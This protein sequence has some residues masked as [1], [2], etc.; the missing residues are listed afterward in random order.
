[1][2]S[3]SS[4]N[5]IY[6]VS[7]SVNVKTYNGYLTNVV[8]NDTGAVISLKT[9]EKISV[10]P[11]DTIIAN[12]NKTTDPKYRTYYRS[13]NINLSGE[14]SGRIVSVYNSDFTFNRFLFNIKHEISKRIGLESGKVY[15]LVNALILGDK[16]GLTYEEK[17]IL[18]SS[19]V[20][21]ICAV[22]GLHVSIVALFIGFIISLL[23]IKKHS[24][25][26][27]ITLPVLFLLLCLSG[28]TISAIRAVFMASAALLGRAFYRKADSLNLL[29]LILT[30]ILIVSPFSAFSPSLLLTFFA[31]FGIVLLSNNI[32]SELITGIFLQ[33]GHIVPKPF[34]FILRIISVSIAATVF[35][36]TITEIFFSNTTVL[37]V[38]SNILVLQLVTPVYIFS[39]LMIVF[40]FIP[41]CGTVTLLFAQLVTLGVNMIFT[42]SSWLSNSIFAKTDIALG[43]I[44]VCVIIALIIA[45]IYY[46]KNRPKSKK[47]KRK[48]IAYSAAVFAISFIVA[49][50]GGTAIKAIFDPDDGFYHVAYIDVGQGMSSVVSYGNSAVIIDCGG[51]KNASYAINNYLHSKSIKNIDTII[52]SHLHSDHCNAINSLLDEWN[53]TE[54]IIPYT[55]G[56]PAIYLD[57]IE[58][59]NQFGTEVVEIE[60]DETRK[61]GNMYLC[62]LT[63]HLSEENVDQNDNC[64]AVIADINGG[65]RAIFPGDLTE[66]SE[67]VLVEKYGSF[68]DCNVLSVPHHGSKYSS[69]SLFLETVS[70]MLSIISV[71]KNSFGHPTKEATD[72]I[73]SAG[74]K[75]MTTLEYGTIEIVTDGAGFDVV[76][77]K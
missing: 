8:C 58:K 48:Y 49:L 14:A 12:I 24:I 20:Y 4:N 62:I 46:L 29:G 23:K 54:V 13:V 56:D 21:H 2:S 70:P 55:E 53:V 74:S 10:S 35:T 52:V 31:T 63:K 39:L 36:V 1:M 47:K 51:S 40:S 73:L 69:S 72:R 5:N 67:S 77:G 25:K 18:Q 60:A 15:G 37:G 65:F 30:L 17:N 43:T 11:D 66:I 9:A 64:L 22:S 42:V 41:F 76:Y 38:V 44:A 32:K 50:F 71:G 68:L 6:T 34:A 16:S 45:G 57:L 27:L 33:T 59:A 3:L 28:F 19:G 61:L 75:I 7:D 26:L